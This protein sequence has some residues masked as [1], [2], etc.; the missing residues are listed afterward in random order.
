MIF[1]TTWVPLGPYHHRRVAAMTLQMLIKE[2]VTLLKSCELQF[3]LLFSDCYT[4]ILFGNSKTNVWSTSKIA[5]SC[6]KVCRLG[7][8]K[9]RETFLIFHWQRTWR[10]PRTTTREMRFHQNNMIV[11]PIFTVAWDSQTGINNAHA[12]WILQE[13][14]VLMKIMASP[15]LLKPST[16]KDIAGYIRR[17]E[18][19]PTVP[20]TMFQVHRSFGLPGTVLERVCPHLGAF[21]HN[22]AELETRKTLRSGLKEEFPIQFVSIY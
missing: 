3:F 14:S 6:A 15:L 4:I 18:P 5:V 11:R 1:I 8:W 16:E 12:L 17:L 9:Q 19:V 2:K 21:G 10:Q 22:N 20:K 7:K 13:P